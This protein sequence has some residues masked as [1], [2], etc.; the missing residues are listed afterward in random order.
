MIDIIQLSIKVGRER[1]EQKKVRHPV[2]NDVIESQLFSL[3]ITSQKVKSQ[4]D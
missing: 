4:H 3:I 1:E 2:V